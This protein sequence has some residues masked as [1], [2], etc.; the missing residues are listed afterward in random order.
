MSDNSRPLDP[1]IVTKLM[2]HILREEKA[3]LLLKKT[4]TD[5]I[6]SIQKLIYDRANSDIKQMN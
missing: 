1:E 5:T 4:D 6:K 2:I 3:S